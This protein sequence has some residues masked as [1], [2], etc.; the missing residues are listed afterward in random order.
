MPGSPT[1]A[2]DSPTEPQRLPSDA[3]IREHSEP[4]PALSDAQIREQVTLTFAH[5]AT[6]RSTVRWPQP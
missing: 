4:D 6:C 1:P 2:T 3:Q 5:L